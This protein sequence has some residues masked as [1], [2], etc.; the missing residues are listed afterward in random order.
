MEHGGTPAQATCALG[1]PLAAPL[2]QHECV[3]A[4]RR[5]ARRSDLAARVRHEKPWQAT[6]GSVVDLGAG[7]GI[8][9][10]KTIGVG[11]QGFN[12]ANNFVLFFDGGQL[13]R[14]TSLR[15][16]R[17]MFLWARRCRERFLLD[18]MMTSNGKP[19]R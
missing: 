12:P 10:F 1:Y 8:A 6:Q 2:A 11:D 4:A 19:T 7:G 18:R 9:G 15:L 5:R 17:L 14:R 16:L 13:E 3:P